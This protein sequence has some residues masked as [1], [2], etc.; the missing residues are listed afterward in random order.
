MKGIFKKLGDN[1]RKDAL[2]SRYSF[3]KATRGFGYTEKDID[4][5][6]YGFSLGDDELEGVAGGTPRPSKQGSTMH[7]NN[8]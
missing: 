5:A 8:N 4:S 7:D 1:G 2:D 6:L 3:R